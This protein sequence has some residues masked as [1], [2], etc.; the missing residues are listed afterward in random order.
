MGIDDT[1]T[2]LVFN[3]LDSIEDIEKIDEV[4]ENYPSAVFISCKKGEGIEV[5]R[6]KI[7]SECNERYNISRWTRVKIVSIDKNI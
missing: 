1:E 6:K 2:I 5:L 4:Q 7:I 3:K